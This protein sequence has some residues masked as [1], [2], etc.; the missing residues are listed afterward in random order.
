MGKNNRQ[1]RAAKQRRRIQQQR[2]HSS[3][4]SPFGTP[5]D[6]AGGREH[7]AA[8]TR[9]EVQYVLGEA[10]FAKQAGDERTE[11]A[12]LS[13]LRSLDDSFPSLVD[14]VVVPWLETMVR[15]L[16][17]GGWQPADLAELGRRKLAPPE[18]RVLVDVIVFEHQRYSG[19]AI[20]VRWRNQLTELATGPMWTSSAGTDWASRWGAT[21][22]DALLAAVA[23]GALL[24]TL[25]R[26]PK[27]LPIPGDAAARVT[28]S[29]SANVDDK[30]LGRIRGLLAKAESTDF[31]EEAEALSSKAQEMMSKYSLDRALLDAEAGDQTNG[32][33]GRRIW[34]DAPY[35]SAKNHLVQVV[36]SANGCKAVGYDQLG[37]VTILGSE[38]DL[39]LVEV[40]STSLLVQASRAMLRTKRQVGQQGQSRT[41]SYRQSFLLSYAARIGERLQEATESAMDDADRDRLLPVL[42][43]RDEQVDA[44]FT[45]LFPNVVTRRTSVSNYAGWAAGRAAADQAS[46]NAR[47]PVNR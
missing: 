39:Q 36:A 2:S 14:R 15:W 31:P 4:G 5:S 41:R 19:A 32:P 42:A 17:E 18:Q 12:H 21:R 43:R 23:S 27:L 6:P 20:D 45:E 8:P 16:W 29:K 46:L 30:I 11:R 47:P 34:V 10:A 25:P 22:W 1:R 44:L 35:V 28:S 9:E 37:F 7:I 24:K 13:T 40:L 38:V 26:L 3:S 33:L